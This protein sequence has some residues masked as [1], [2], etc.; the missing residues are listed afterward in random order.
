[1]DLYIYS[2]YTPSWGGQEQI[3]LL[4]FI[5][6]LKFNNKFEGV[7]QTLLQM[8]ALFSNLFGCIFYLYNK[9]NKPIMYILV[10]K[11]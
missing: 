3:Y 5:Q 8:I 6:R 7:N 11:T 9:I 2:P 10:I 1:M 4:T